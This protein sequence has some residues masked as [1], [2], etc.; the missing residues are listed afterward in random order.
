MGMDDVALRANSRVEF[1][2]REGSTG[3]LWASNLTLP[4]VSSL[5]FLYLH[6]RKEMHFLA[7]CRNKDNMGDEHTASVAVEDT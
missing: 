5:R 2:R 4:S 6:N 1:L 7:S 3:G